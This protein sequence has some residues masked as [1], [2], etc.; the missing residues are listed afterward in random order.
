MI[1]TQCGGTVAATSGSWSAP[2]AL[3]C[4]SRSIPFP[5]SLLRSE[6]SR[7]S[8]STVAAGSADSVGGPA[9]T[10]TTGSAVSGPASPPLPARPLASCLAG[11]GGS[12]RS[13]RFRTSSTVAGEIPAARATSRSEDSGCW[14]N[15][16]AARRRPSPLFSGRTR[17]S[18]PT[19]APDCGAASPARFLMAATLF[20]ASPAEWPITRSDRCGCDATIRSA[21]ARR[22]AWDSG[23]PWAMFSWTARRKTSASLPSKNLTSI[24]SCPCNDAA[25]RRCIPSIT[26]ML[27]L[28]T[29]IGGSGVSVSTSRATCA[30][31]SPFNRGESAGRSASIGMAVTGAPESGTCA[32]RPGM[33]SRERIAPSAPWF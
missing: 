25:I 27:R 31:S 21:A 16:S 5:R 4:S 15:S 10:G 11:T 1:A 13:R 20:A 30:L 6:G 24:V 19:R 8:F 7:S 32:A 12:P 14:A 29:R 23:S 28:S 2:T 18:R 33:P 17:P 3:T 22:S 26:R 9:W